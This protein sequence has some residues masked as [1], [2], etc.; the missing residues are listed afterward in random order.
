MS[1]L[2]WL[3]SLCACVGGP[4]SVPDDPDPV[5]PTAFEDLPRGAWSYVP[6]EGMACGNGAPTGI[7]VH[8]GSTD[9]VLLVVAGGGACWDA[10]TCFVL[11]SA[12][13]VRGGW[14]EAQ[15]GSETSGLADFPLLDRARDDNPFREATWIYVPYCTGDLHAGRTV[16]AYVA[17]EPDNRLHHV[18]DA[19]FQ[20]LLRA[21]QSEIPAP[22]R[23]W[24]IG[25]SAGGYGVQLQADRIAGAW[26]EAEVALLADGAPMI[27]PA[28]GRWG[29][30]RSAWDL[31]F[32]D[33]CED[34][35][36]GLPQVLAHQAAALPAVRLG[37]LTFLDDD[38]IA[39]YLNYPAGG[40][41]RATV[42]LL[43]GPYSETGVAAFA[44]PGDEHVMIGG[45]DERAAPDGTRLRD[46]ITA[47]ALGT[48][49]FV[50][51]R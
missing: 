15:L 29:E 51:A 43:D 48:G 11:N 44:L 41:E 13:H 24:A 38:V 10:L 47:W 33:G 1:R 22:S 6:V 25:L 14:G 5:E 49:G 16:K 42:A 30:F 27:R 35:G 26:P 9:E 7:G 18:G 39:L 19:N 8:P 21:V 34:C 36:E 28:G 4:P 37:L 46:W 3:S 2:V 17:W 20:A 45:L 50:T 12:V 32:P 23:A 40:V 31:R